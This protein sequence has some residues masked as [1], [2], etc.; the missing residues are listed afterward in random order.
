MIKKALQTLIDHPR[1]LLIVIILSF[2]MGLV[3]VL[4]VVDEYSA[5]RDQAE[6]L[7]Q[8][9]DE[10]GVDQ[11]NLPKFEQ[12]IV[13][14]QAELAALEA[15]AISDEQASEF[16]NKMVSLVRESGCQVR[17]VSLGEPRQRDWMENDN[18]V[19]PLQAS[20]KKNNQTGF[21]LKSRV[22]SLSVSGSPDHVQ[23]LL[24]TLN[25]AQPLAH[26][27]S[28]SVRPADNSRDEVILELELWLFELTKKVPVSA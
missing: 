14:Q 11:E 26:T 4:P 28:L 25:A 6:K 27:R 5:L 23:G 8:E 21:E 7:L 20:N 13:Q 22:F 17:R 12:R 24:A 3:L 10:A 9:L 15:R 1:G 18:P 19:K 16:R 2:G